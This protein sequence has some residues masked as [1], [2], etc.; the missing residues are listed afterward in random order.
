MLGKV[1]KIEEK[2]EAKKG[3]DSKEQEVKMIDKYV[4]ILV[5]KSPDMSDLYLDSGISLH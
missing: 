2:K 1:M 3:K 5:E 4:R